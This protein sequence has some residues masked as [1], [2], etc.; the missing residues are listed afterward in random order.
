ML[1][2]PYLEGALAAAALSDCASTGAGNVPVVS[3]G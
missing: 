1:F 2:E 3:E